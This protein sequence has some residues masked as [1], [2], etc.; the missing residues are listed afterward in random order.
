M[1]LDRVLDLVGPYSTVP[2]SPRRLTAAY[3][4]PWFHNYAARS[5]A[6]GDVGPCGGPFEE[7]VSSGRSWDADTARAVAVIENLERAALNSR[8]RQ[9][10]FGPA[11]D[12]PDALD[13]ALLPRCSD[14]E[15]AD[16]ECPLSAP[17]PAVPVSWV[18]G[19]QPLTG[20]PIHLPTAMVHHTW[21]PPSRAARWWLPISTG[22]AV[23]PTRAAA[24]A[25]GV[26]E[27]LERDIVAVAWLQRLALPRLDSAL[28]TEGTHRLVEWCH[29]TYTEAHFFDATTEIGVPIVYCVLESPYD[30]VGARL[31]AA[32]TGP[33]LADAAESALTE[34]LYLR[35]ALHWQAALPGPP[36]TLIQG[37]LRLGGPGGADDLDFLLHPDDPP[38]TPG[39]VASPPVDA[40]D[41][42]RLDWLLRRCHEAGHPVY[43]T[44]LTTPELAGAGLHAAKVVI[45]SLQPLNFHYRAQYKGHPRLYRLPG[46]LGRPA[47]PEG[48]LNPLPQPFA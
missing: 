46:L 18:P 25:S 37:A 20:T 27:V 36:P 16:P 42:E 40:D 19:V 44:D 32:S 35:P 10:L 39:T 48:R 14:R 13:P 26:R 2:V 15:L 47:L 28:H 7:T 4:P 8:P 45:P 22:A 23:G 41:E 21:R 11:T 1:S 34:V 30:R 38:V 3:L 12:V 9:T 31:V 24:I 43:A 6:R 17:D 5:P 29:R 33:T